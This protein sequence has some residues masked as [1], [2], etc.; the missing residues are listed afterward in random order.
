MGRVF[1]LAA[2]IGVGFFLSG[3][4]SSRSTQPVIINNLPPS[5]SGATVLLTVLIIGVLLATVTSVVGW[6]KFSSERAAHADLRHALE[7]TTGMS[8]PRLRAEMT[9]ADV[10]PRA[11]DRP[12]PVLPSV[13]VRGH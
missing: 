3:C 12:V 5:D 8:V 4:G 2:L 7:L 1:S 11:A 13:V 6:M 9:L 10:S